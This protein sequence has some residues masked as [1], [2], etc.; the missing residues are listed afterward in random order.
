M[1]IVI[2]IIRLVRMVF[3]FAKVKNIDVKIDWKKK[4]PT[5][6]CS[7]SKYRIDKNCGFSG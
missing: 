2:R 4:K 3:I 7:L 1:I 5:A 6:S